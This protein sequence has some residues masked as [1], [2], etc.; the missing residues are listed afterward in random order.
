MPPKMISGLAGKKKNHK[1]KIYQKVRAS[2]PKSDFSQQEKKK[3][4]TQILNK[5][6]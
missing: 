5:T 4:R 1:K 2:P 3:N 6:F